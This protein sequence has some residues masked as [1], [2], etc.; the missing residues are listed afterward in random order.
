MRCFEKEKKEAEEFIKLEDLSCRIK[1]LEGST[2]HI[3][4]P[5]RKL[6]FEGYLTII[7]P[8]N[9]AQS[10]TFSR[11]SSSTISFA[12]TAETPRLK[13]RNST[14]NIAL[15]KQ[16]RAYVFLFNDLIVCTRVC[17][18]FIITGYRFNLIS[19]KEIK[20]SQW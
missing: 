2:V 15:K 17:Y 11:M 18:C 1:G 16:D 4:E 9:P 6:I 14:F 3:A 5:K 8:N 19:R 20:E 13:R 10:G 7:P 12:S